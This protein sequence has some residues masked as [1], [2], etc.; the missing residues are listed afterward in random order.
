MQPLLVSTYALHSH[1]GCSTILCIM[2][3]PGNSS[4]AMYRQGSPQKAQRI[5]WCASGTANMCSMLTAVR[6][7][8]AGIALMHLAWKG[9]L[10]YSL[11]CSH[12]LQNLSSPSWQLDKGLAGAPSMFCR[13]MGFWKKMTEA[14]MTITRLR[15]L[16]MEC[17]TGV[18]RARIMYDTCMNQNE[19]RRKTKVMKEPALKRYC[20]S[21]QWDASAHV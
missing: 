16:P 13:D 3:I 8:S 6:W 15:Q 10:N 21:Q 12:V 18:T 5:P 17:V 1:R 9:R 7:N 20:A 2:Q 4:V 14:T 19:M 11:A